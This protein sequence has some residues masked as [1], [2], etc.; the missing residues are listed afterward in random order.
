MGRLVKCRGCSKQVN[1]DNAYCHIHVTSSGNKQNWWYC[2][3]EEFEE[4]EKEKRYLLECK[5]MTDD[6]MGYEITNNVRNKFL[7]EL[8]K[9]NYSYEK[10]FYCIQDN[11]MAIERALVLKRNDLNNEYNTLAYMFG[12][13]KKEI[14]KYGSKTNNKKINSDTLDPSEIHN[15]KRKVKQE[16]KSLM[17]KIRGKRDGK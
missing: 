2:S 3:Q 9:A 5:Y 4:I 1:T 10:I 14:S 17:D 7:S 11:K 13:I 16:K 12:I 8:N 6:I 15:N